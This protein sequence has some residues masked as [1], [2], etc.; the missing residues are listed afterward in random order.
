MK[1]TT[2]VYLYRRRLRAHLAQELLA[3]LGVAIAVALLFAVTVADGSIASSATEV[4]HAVIGP[5]N[6]QLR[7]RGSGG[8]DEGVLARVEA[9]PGVSQAAPS[10]R[11]DR[12]RARPRTGDRATVQI[13]GADLSLAL[14]DGLAHTIPLAALS[15]NGIGLSAHTAAAIGAPEPSRAGAARARHAAARH[16]RARRAATFGA[17]A[18]APVAV[19]ALARLQAL[20]GLPR[21]RSRG[22]SF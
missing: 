22:S 2:L 12:E 20:A 7:A 11:T 15:A 16:R 21:R 14:L 17:L 9:L 6:L 13:A 3:G 5:A 8:F 19:M 18:S 4:V 1:P 10:A